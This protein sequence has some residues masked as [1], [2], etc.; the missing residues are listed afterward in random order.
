MVVVTLW[1]TILTSPHPLLSVARCKQVEGPEA[2]RVFMQ[3]IPVKPFSETQAYARSELC[4]SKAAKAEARAKAEAAAAAQAAAAKKE[5]EVA[6]KVARKAKASAA[7]AHPQAG[8]GRGGRAPPRKSPPVLP[9]RTPPRTRRPVAKGSGPAHMLGPLSPAAR[10]RRMEAGRAEDDVGSD[11]AQG[12]SK[13][14]DPKGNPKGDVEMGTAAPPAYD[15]VGN[16]VT[17][18]NDEGEVCSICL[19]EL[20]DDD[21]AKEL[22]CLHAFHADCL[23]RWLRVSTLCPLCKGKAVAIAGEEINQSF[24]QRIAYVRGLFSE[25]KT[26]KHRRLSWVLCA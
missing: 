9:P 26:K 7:R 20:E 13:G 6:R 25:K 15:E 10:L 5:A 11:Q 23:D 14:D 12:S 21:A 18:A 2:A 1:Y 4:Q 8:F 24:A 16:E 3:R 22:A 19:C 17:S